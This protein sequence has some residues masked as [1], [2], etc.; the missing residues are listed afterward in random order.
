M[1]IVKHG[2]LKFR[3]FA[4]HIC[5]CEFVGDTREYSIIDHCGVDGYEACCPECGN[6]T[7]ISEP[8]EEK[9]DGLGLV[10]SE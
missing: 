6:Y 2:V 5:G 4:C 10:L 1:R 3:K 9:D 8:W 7:D